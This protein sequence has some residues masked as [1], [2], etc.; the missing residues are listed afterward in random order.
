M[1]S[2]GKRLFDYD[3]ATGTTKWW[4][5]D[6]DRDEAKIETV[7]EVGDL[8]ERNKKEYAATDERAR[9]GEQG[10]VARP[11]AQGRAAADSGR[12]PAPRDW[13]WGGCPSPGWPAAAPQELDRRS[14]AAPAEPKGPGQ[15]ERRL[16]K[17]RPGNA[18]P[19]TAAW[20]EAARSPQGRHG[21]GKNGA[22]PESEVGGF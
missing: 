19:L 8:V 3:P 12:E 6:A 11:G 14:L 15:Q 18:E 1:S 13:P 20:P 10:S 22:Q 21:R 9:W 4:H 7:F 2:T 16:P 17:E 5:Y